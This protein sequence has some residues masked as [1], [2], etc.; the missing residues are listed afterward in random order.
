MSRQSLKSRP[1]SMS[2]GID[3]KGIRKTALICAAI[4]ASFYIG[5]I[6]MGVLNS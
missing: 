1:T 6:L 4:A 2:A 5:F 3:K